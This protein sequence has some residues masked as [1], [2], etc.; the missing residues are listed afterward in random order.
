MSENKIQIKV[1]EPLKSFDIKTKILY[2]DLPK[3][4]FRW[5]LIGSTGSGKT[6][7]I[8]NIV[9]NFYKEYFDEIYI[10]IGSID[11]KE[12]YERLSELTTFKKFNKKK[13][14]LYKSK[15]GYMSDK[16]KVMNNITL[17]QIEELYND[18][19]EEQ[20]TENKKIRT[21]FIFDDMITD[22]IF[23]RNMS[24]NVMDK[25]F[26]Q[27]RHINLSVIISSQKYTAL[28]PN[29]RTQNSSHLTIFN[30]LTNKAIK[31]ISRENSG[32]I[33]EETFE[34]LY[35][36]TTK[37]RYSFLHINKFNPKNRKFQDKNF[38]YINVSK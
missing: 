25:L 31:E 6:N 3:P 5:V 17:D 1:Y 32:H 38:N 29:I 7:L 21:L 33:D 23:K 22:N 36:D 2:K 26:V 8:K 24:L 35:F 15:K 16:V 13:G 27:G 19:E 30:G 9:F 18:I 4:S 12:E 37:E 11:D 20:S 10:F 28:N 34:N 14:E